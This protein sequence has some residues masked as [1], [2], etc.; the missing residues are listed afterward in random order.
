MQVKGKWE[1]IHVLPKFEAT[2]E[3]LLKEGYLKKL[4]K[5]NEDCLILE[6]VDS[7]KRDGTV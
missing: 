7:A 1:H 6:T 5:C 3:K 2:I 4:G